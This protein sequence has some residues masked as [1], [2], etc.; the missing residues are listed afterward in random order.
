MNRTLSSGWTFFYK[1]LFPVVW[2]GGFAIGA[3]VAID[4]GG[5]SM[6]D[7]WRDGA[8]PDM[9]WIL[10]L[11][12]LI[13]VASTVWL[14]A[15]LKRVQVDDAGDLVVSNYLHEWRVP[16]S[17]ITEV[18]QNRWLKMRPITLRLRA[19]MGCGTSVMFMPPSRL[20]F[21]FWQEDPE[22]EEL[23]QLAGIR[24]PS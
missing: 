21:R 24:A 15:P 7:G 17:L 12:G 19:D 14:T 1:Y 4:N 10:L 2:I 9:V 5:V 20:R 16:V 8:P 11:V 18:K 6:S 13:G 23:R 3:R 22:V